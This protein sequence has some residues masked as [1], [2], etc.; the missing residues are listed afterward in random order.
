MSGFIDIE[1]LGQFSKTGNVSH[2]QPGNRKNPTYFYFSDGA[3]S[4]Y[5]KQILIK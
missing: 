5:S 3:V 1:K 2:W 4:I